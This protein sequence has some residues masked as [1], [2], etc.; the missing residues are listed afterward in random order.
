M[1]KIVSIGVVLTSLLFVNNLE[2]KSGY[3]LVL[4]VTQAKKLNNTIQRVNSV[5]KNINN[6]ILKTGKLP[7]KSNLSLPS[8][9]YEAYQ[10]GKYF[11]FSIDKEKVIFKDLLPKNFKKR[12]LLVNS[13]MLLPLAVVNGDNTITIA[14]DPKV[15]TYLKEYDNYQASQTPPSDK[16]KIW[17]K[18]NG[19]G[20]FDIYKYDGSKWSMFESILIT[21]N[22]KQK[23]TTY[24]LKDTDQLNKIKAKNGDI[25][26]INKGTKEIKKYIYD[27]SSAKWLMVSASSGSSVYTCKDDEIGVMKFDKDQN[28]MASCQKVGDKPTWECVE[29]TIATKSSQNSTLLSYYYYLLLN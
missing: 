9:S 13:P 2:A 12:S 8:K 20:G 28:C 1:K 27:T 25:A 15:I 22:G 18:P 23:T 5:Y 17:Y 26:Y 14:L 7:T 19:N 29:K 24:T 4:E 16:N 10:K 21:Q 11:D 6:Y 3:E